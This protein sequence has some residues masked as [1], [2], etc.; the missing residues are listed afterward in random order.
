[1]RTFRS[2]WIMA[3]AVLDDGVHSLWW[4]G[5]QFVMTKQTG[6]H[7]VTRARGNPMTV[8]ASVDRRAVFVLANLGESRGN[9][10]RKLVVYFVLTGAAILDDSIWFI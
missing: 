9:W 1:M 3:D 5:T 4:R 6:L 10:Y 8:R 2:G 7:D